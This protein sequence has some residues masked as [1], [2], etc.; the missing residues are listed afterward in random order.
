VRHAL[1]ADVSRTYSNGAID[2]NERGAWTTALSLLTSLKDKLT[3]TAAVEFQN[4]HVDRPYWGT[5]LLNPTI[6]VGRINDATRF[7]N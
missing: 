6:G 1:R 4:E 2:G 5:L 3:H 7:K